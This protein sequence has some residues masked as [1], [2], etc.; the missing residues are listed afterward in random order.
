[1]EAKVGLARAH[2]ARSHHYVEAARQDSDERVAGTR[3]AYRPGRPT[4]QVVEPPHTPNPEPQM[5]QLFERGE[6]PSRL[7]NLRKRDQAAASRLSEPYDR[8]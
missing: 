8:C 2:A 1:M 4:R 7:G 3:L 6:V 5:N